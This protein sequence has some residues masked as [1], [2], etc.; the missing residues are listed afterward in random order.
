MHTHR[1]T[2]TLKIT[3]NMSHVCV[4]VSLKSRWK[5]CRLSGRGNEPISVPE[6]LTHLT[7]ATGATHST[8]WHNLILH[9]ITQVSADR[10]VSVFISL[11]HTLYHMRHAGN[12]A[13]KTVHFCRLTRA[14]T[15][16]FKIE[17]MRFGSH[18]FV[19]VTDL[20]S[21]LL[22]ACDWTTE[23]K[24]HLSTHSFTYYW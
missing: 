6:T 4:R 19:F 23:N 12:I 15:K 1:V 7:P 17:N 24:P 2:L 22:P 16:H 14:H 3:W 10:C 11:L 5:I 13:Y 18:M 20:N 9:A 8:G 21:I